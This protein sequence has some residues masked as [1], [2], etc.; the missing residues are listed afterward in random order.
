MAIE[1]MIAIIKAAPNATFQL[2]MI[3]VKTINGTITESVIVQ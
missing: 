3:N 1:Y 2:I